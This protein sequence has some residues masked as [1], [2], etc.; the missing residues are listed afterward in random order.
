MEGALRFPAPY[1][2]TRHGSSS[3][4]GKPLVSESLPQGAWW[5]L[6]AGP[7]RLLLVRWPQWPCILERDVQPDGRVRSKDRLFTGSSLPCTPAPITTDDEKMSQREPISCS[8]FSF[9]LR[10]D[11]ENPCQVITPQRGRC[12]SSFPAKSG[13]TRTAF[14]GGWC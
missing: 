2:G 5:P 8:L 10:E 4:L 12:W 3:P 14:H 9:N 1:V 7:P 6:V 13:T 11:G